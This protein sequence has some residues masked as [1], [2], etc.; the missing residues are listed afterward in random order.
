MFKSEEKEKPEGEVL[1]VLIYYFIYRTCYD[2]YTYYCRY[3][4]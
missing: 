1:E 3:N 2:D 4:C